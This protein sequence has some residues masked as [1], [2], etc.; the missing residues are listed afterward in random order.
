MLQIALLIMGIAGLVKRKIKVTSKREISGAP[1]ILLSCFYL[2][3]A[4]FMFLF[5]LDIIGIIM[6]IGVVGFVTLLVVIFAKGKP[7]GSI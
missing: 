4:L 2:L 7:V 6:V 5:R 3:L 1:V